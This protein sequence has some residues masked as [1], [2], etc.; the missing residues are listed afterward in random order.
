MNRVQVHSLRIPELTE[1][2]RTH[3]I[4]LPLD[5]RPFLR[6]ISIT[7]SFASSS[8]CSVCRALNN[9][10]MRSCQHALHE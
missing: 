8:R 1:A 6:C 10:P 3:H 2:A 4:D 9:Q 5:S 7:N